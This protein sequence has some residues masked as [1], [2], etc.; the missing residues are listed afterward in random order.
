MGRIKMRDVYVMLV[1]TLAIFYRMYIRRYYDRVEHVELREL[2]M[3]S[4]AREVNSAEALY[5][6]RIAP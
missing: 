1:D 2:T 3:P 5:G 4:D 6:H